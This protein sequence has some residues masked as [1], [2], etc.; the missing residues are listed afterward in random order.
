MWGLTEVTPTLSFRL[1]AKWVLAT[2]FAVAGMTLAALGVVRFV[3]AETSVNPLKPGGVS[4]LVTSG[5]YRVTR[6]P[7]Y[8]GM[9]LFLGG[10]ACALSH[11][12][13]FAMLP[14][15]V[16]YMNRFQIGPEEA[17]LSGIFGNAYTTYRQ[18]VRRWL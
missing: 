8:V 14:L 1:P 10:M 4:A 13:A 17:A 11:P 3:R 5:V 9:L 12:L 2:A 6:N 18:R 16:I 15:F 7:M